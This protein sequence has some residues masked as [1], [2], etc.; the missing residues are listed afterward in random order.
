MIP[1]VKNPGAASKAPAARRSNRKRETTK[2]EAVRH[3]RGSNRWVLAARSFAARITNCELTDQAAVDL[4]AQWRLEIDAQE[5]RVVEWFA[6]AK[7]AAFRAHAAICQ[8]ENEALTPYREARRALNSKLAVWQAAQRRL[9]AA[10]ETQA[11]TGS[12]SGGEDGEIVTGDAWASGNAPRVEG[13]SFRENWRAD[14][15]DKAAFV[16]AVASKPELVNLL[17]ANLA[18]LGH[19]ARAHKSALNLPGVRV[20]CEYIVAASRHA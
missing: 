3:N 5:R 15:V 16:A 18:A 17:D 10:N 13:V 20:W 7:Q 6:P 9:R 4:A 2:R 14:V 12:L 1:I 8:Q 11:D 19:L